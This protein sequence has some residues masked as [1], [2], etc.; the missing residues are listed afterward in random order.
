MPRLRL[1][2]VLLVLCLIASLPALASAAEPSEGGLIAQCSAEADSAL[3]DLSLR[4][5]QL[6]SLSEP[7]PAEPVVETPRD[8]PAARPSEKPNVEP[9]SASAA[10]AGIEALAQ[11]LASEAQPKPGGIGFEFDE[12]I[13]LGDPAKGQQA[14]R[15]N[16]FIENQRSLARSCLM[17]DRPCGGGFQVS[18]GC[19]IRKATRLV[20]GI[21][22]EDN[23]HVGRSDLRTLL[24][25]TYTF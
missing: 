9:G 11:K 24:G 10:L 17:D 5:C 12:V 15:T 6:S 14:G 25:V 2:P 1:V 21:Q 23:G 8:C 7:Q 13:S 4:H 16:A 18:V 22:A 20:F 19:P 3:A